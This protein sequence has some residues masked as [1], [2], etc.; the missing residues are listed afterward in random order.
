M[1]IGILAYGSLIGEPG[2][3]LQPF[4]AATFD[5]VVT[6]FPVEFARSSGTRD[7]A[8]TLIPVESGGAQVNGKVLVLAST[9]DLDHAKT[10]LWR[11]ETRK[12][13]STKRYRRP[14]NPGRDHVLVESIDEF[15]EL[16][17][18]LFTNIGSNIK[19][20]TE[21]GLATLAIRS[22]R[23]EAGAKGRDGISYLS[24]VIDQGV[25]T[26]LLPGYRDAILG[27]TGANDLEEAHRLVRLQTRDDI[28]CVGG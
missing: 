2:E 24:S 23:A 11:R 9:I 28:K 14:R 21:E 22:A 13:F 12:E 17:T 27:K 7:G 19:R 6:P 8:P 20:P 16:E 25:V 1:S 4:I 5:G 10:L 15:A 26:P 3:E 18:V